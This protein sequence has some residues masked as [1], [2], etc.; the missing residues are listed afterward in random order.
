MRMEERVPKIKQHGA[1]TRGP[2]NGD[3]DVSNSSS[4]EE[5][6]VRIGNTKNLLVPPGQGMSG[7]EPRKIIRK[8]CI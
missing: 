2:D 8:P 6:D 3:Q 5:A 1:W 4:E 7:R